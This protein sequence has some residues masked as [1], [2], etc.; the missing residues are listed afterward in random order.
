MRNSPRSP[1]TLLDAELGDVT[2]ADLFAMRTLALQVVSE[3]PDQVREDAFT[4]ALFAARAHRKAVSA[5]VAQVQIRTRLQLA[6]MTGERTEHALSATAAETAAGRDREYLAAKG[7]CAEAVMVAE[8]AAA[9][10]R[11]LASLAGLSGPHAAPAFTRLA[12]AA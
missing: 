5:E 2:L 1:M 6:Y 4:A 7:A 9:I 12:S 11:D 8:A 3:N 10:A